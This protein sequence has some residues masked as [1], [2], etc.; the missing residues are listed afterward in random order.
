MAFGDTL[1]LAYQE[2]T[3]LQREGGRRV[4]SGMD[5]V[6]KQSEAIAAKTGMIVKQGGEQLGQSMDWLARETE[7]QVKR[8]NAM[9]HQLAAAA[10][11]KAME[12]GTKAKAVASDAYQA[13]KAKA[14]STAQA[15][16]AVYRKAKTATAAAVTATATTACRYGNQAKKAVT[17]TLNR[18]MENAAARN[19]EAG[20]WDAKAKGGVEA[21][22]RKYKEAGSEE[23]PGKF[24]KKVEAKVQRSVERSALFYGDEDNNI[25]IG[26]YKSALAVGYERDVGNK[27]DTYGLYGELSIAGA[28]A[29]GKGTAVKG[30]VEGS[31]T[32]EALS[33]KVTGMV[34]YVDGKGFKGVK[35]EVGVEANLI[36]GGIGG[37][38]NI[39]PKTLYDNTLGRAVGLVAPDWSEFPAWDWAGHGIFVGAEAELGI[40]A[41]AKGVAQ[42]NA[43]NMSFKLGGLIGAGPMAGIYAT[44]GLK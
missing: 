21:D 29:Q 7:E 36:K 5:W 27:R 14:T 31:A 9:A 19:R 28:T 12:Y 34:G 10:E 6:G 26:V 43:E 38:V 4:A 2:A 33:A 13:G 8:A 24:E 44:F 15:A 35:A 11:Q 40:G 22:R 1:R 18:G 23:G 32:A 3:E 37:Q 30:L 42:F 20:S 39:T 25:K 16:K 17:D 41:A